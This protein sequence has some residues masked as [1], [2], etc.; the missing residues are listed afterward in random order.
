MTCNK[1]SSATISSLSQGF[2]ARTMCYATLRSESAR[3]VRRTRAARTAC[4]RL[5][6]SATKPS[7]PWTV[8]SLHVSRS[9]CLINAIFTARS[10]LQVFVFL[11]PTNTRPSYT[12][13]IPALAKR[14][15]YERPNLPVETLISSRSLQFANPFGAANPTTF[16]TPLFLV[17]FVF[18]CRL[19]LDRKIL[20]LVFRATFQITRCVS[21]IIFLA[22]YN[23]LFGKYIVKKSVIKT[24]IAR[25]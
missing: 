12:S 24:E 13:D 9:A 3:A 22:E 19:F 20:Y 18:L 17:L 23:E 8:A 15:N 1:L 4:S 16:T 10:Q 11:P 6:I 21:H 14:Q 25:K 2:R 7:G 5:L